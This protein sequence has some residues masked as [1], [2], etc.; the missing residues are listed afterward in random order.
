M[1]TRGSRSGDAAGFTLVEVLLA[2]ALLAAAGIAAVGTLGV[3]SKSSE[4]GRERVTMHVRASAMLE[5]L[6]VRDF[7]TLAVTE[8]S[9]ATPDG[10][11]WEVRISDEAPNLR[12]LSVTVS[13]EGRD[14][15]LES[16][17]APR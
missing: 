7:H 1:S 2:L 8:S 11:A 15:V 9:G 13:H 4:D 14:L 5:S 10:L 3:L 6:L 16:L 12:R 17:R